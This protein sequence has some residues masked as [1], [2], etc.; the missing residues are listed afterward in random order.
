MI[1]LKLRKRKDL[2][3]KNIVITLIAIFFV[4]FIFPNFFLSLAF[5]VYSP[6]WYLDSLSK[7][8]TAYFSFKPNTVLMRE[9]QILNE[10]NTELMQATLEQSSLKLE[11]VE[12]R[13]ISE[14]LKKDDLIAAVIS[15]PNVTIYDTII[16]DIGENKGV[17][18]GDFISMPSNIIVG[19]VIETHKK[20]SKAELFSTFGR[21]IDVTIG[22]KNIQAKAYGQ[23][24]GNLF[25]RLPKDTLI[26][27]G[28]LIRIPIVDNQIVGSV[29]KIDFDESSAYSR[30]LFSLPANIYEMR[31]VSVKKSITS[32]K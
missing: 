30:I 8:N 28:D 23:G 24:N 11:N 32:E 22:P 9:N 29:T 15:K 26:Q 5:Y 25:V 20:F 3:R 10:K 14:N 16:I 12:L 1:F 31:W 13:K 21:E 4:N 19:K 7:D 17:Q 6:I 18:V 27:N 2:I